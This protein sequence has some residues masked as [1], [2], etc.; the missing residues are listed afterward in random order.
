MV[1]PLEDEP[2][3]A[4]SVPGS[5]LGSAPSGRPA[6]NTC[7]NEGVA[8]AVV[9]DVEVLG[10]CCERLAVAVERSGFTNL[11]VGERLTAKLDAFVAEQFY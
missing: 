3:A 11:L 4:V 1:V 10:D 8:Y 2:L 6:L 5:C 9:A 7:S